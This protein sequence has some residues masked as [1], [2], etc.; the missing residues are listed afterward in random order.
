[1]TSPGVPRRS[2]LKAGA[3]AAAF[4]L[5]GCTTAVPDEQD[6]ASPVPSAADGPQATFTFACAARPVTLDPALAVDTESHRITRQILEGLVGADADTSD[7]VPLLA[8][9]WTESDDRRT[10]TFTLREDV[11]F[12]DGQPFNAEAVCVNFNRWFNLPVSAR[13]TDTLMFKSVFNG[14]ADTPASTLFRGCT[15]VDEYTV[16]IELAE[17]LTGFVAALSAPAFAISSPKA[18]A[19]NG[20]DTFTVEQDGQLLSAYATHPVGTGPYAF[21]SWNSDTVTLTSYPGY[22]GKRGQIGTVVFQTMTSPQSRLRALKK[23]E[24]DGYD[25]VTVADVDDL[26]RSGQQILQRDPYSVL[27]LGINQDFPGLD[28]VK[29]RQAIAHAID[30]DALLDGLF[31]N[32]TKPAN[33]FVPQKLGVT[34]ETVTNYGFEPAKA[35]E[36]LEEA[37]YDGTELPFYYPRRVTRSY[38][39]SPEKLYARLSSQLTAAGLNIKPVPVDWSEGYTSQVQNAGDRA[40]HLLG[41]SGTYEDPDNFMGTLF[42]DYSQEFGYDDPLL[43]SRISKARSLASGQKQTEAYRGITDRIS[44]R[45]P[46]IPLAFPISALTVS[47]RVSSYPTSPVLDEV[48]NRITL[49]DA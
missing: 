19:E 31:L 11:T 45:I 12:H 24:V 15:A 33:Q 6:S 46:A 49:T 37:G 27:Y 3:A 13:G 28:N 22:W 35:K 41:L 43:V 23:G 39:P 38:L 10:Y 25:L 8:T 21:T 26:A 48:F 36:L 14:Y 16:R 32:G 47:A 5:T 30:K 7:P 44:E 1:M 18:L 42:G 29:M 4:L 9:S 40:L 34:S 2:L 17:P 20:A